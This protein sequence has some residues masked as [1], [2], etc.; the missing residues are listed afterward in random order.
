MK[1][2]WFCEKCNIGSRVDLDERED[3]VSA[4][5]KIK[6]SHRKVSPM[7]SAYYSGDYIRSINMDLIP[8]LKK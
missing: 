2:L 7:C 6:D 4:L 8:D 1:Q 3:V 5:R